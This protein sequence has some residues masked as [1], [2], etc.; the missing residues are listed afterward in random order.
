M[1]EIGVP[2]LL[3]IYPK[4]MKTEIINHGE[5]EWEKRLYVAVMGESKQ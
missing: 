4:S 1:D 3:L 2:R 5:E